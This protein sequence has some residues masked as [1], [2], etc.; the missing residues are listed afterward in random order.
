MNHGPDWNLYRS[1]LA[2]IET[3]SLSGAARDLGLAQPTVARHVETLEAELGGGALFTRS[4]AGLRPTRAALTI[5]PIARAM[6]SSAEALVR[7]AAGDAEQERGVVRVTASQVVGVEVLPSILRDF[8]EDHP[9]IDIELALGNDLQDLLR[10]DA[11]IA[12]RMARPTQTALLAKKVGTA[13]IAFFAHRDYL[14]RHGMPA[15]IDDLNNH[16]VIGFDRTQPLQVAADQIGFPIT[17]DL[18]ALRTDSDAAQLAAL[19]AGFGIGAAQ[20]NIAARHP[21]LAPVLHNAFGFDL[22]TWVVMHED[23]KSDRRMRLMFDHLVAGLGA[24]LM[25][26]STTP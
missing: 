14:A 5:A 16:A 18:F 9:G 1:F 13:R 10:R 15:T 11:D 26:P 25:S 17:P 20:I 22:P 12:V 24:W 19:R 6:A 23:L 7:T 21:E 3:G 2:V 8:R 4:G